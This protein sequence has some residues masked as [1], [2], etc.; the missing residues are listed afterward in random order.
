MALNFLTGLDI[1]GNVDLN[2]KELQNAVIQNLGTAPS[3]PLEGQIYYD[4][5]VDKLKLYTAG[6]WLTIPD[7]N[8]AANDFL[9]GLGFN[10]SNGV[11]TATV[12]NQSAVTVDLDGRY[13]LTSDIPVVNN[14]TLTLSTSTGLDGGATF[15]A[16]QSGNSTFNVTL[17]LSELA[18]MTQAMVGTDEFI[19]L[20]SGAERRKAAS[21]IGLSIFNNDANFITSGDLPTVGNGT[22]TVQGTGVL[23]GT[24]TF[25][26]NQ[27]T[28]STISITHDNVA[29]TNTTSTGSGTTFAFI[30][31]VSATAQGHLTGV[32]V[33][34]QTIP[35]DNT[36]SL[37]VKN[38]AGNTEFTSTDATGVRFEGGT[39]VTVGFTSSDQTVKINSTDQYQG[40]VTG[41]ATN[42][43]GTIEITASSTVPKVS[44]KTAAIVNNGTALATGDQ[45]YDFVTAQI[46]NIPSGLAFEGSWDAS[47]G[48]APSASPS[49]GQFWIVSVNGSTNLSGITDWKVGDWAIYVEQGAGTDAWQKIDNTSVLSGNGTSGRVTF[50]N[51][52][53]TLTSDA[54]MTYNAS[55]NALTITG[56]MT[57]SGGNSTNWNSAYTATN[58]FT[59]VGANLTKLANPSAI[60]F[61]KI[62]ANNTVTARTASQFRADI[63]AGTS[64]TTGTVRSIATSAPITGGTITDTGT[65]GIS[66]ATSSAVGAARVAAGTGISVAVSNGVFTVTNTERNSQN[67]LAVNVPLNGVIT[68]NFNTKDVIVQLFDATTNQTVYADITRAANTIT[69]SY[70]SPPTN[71]IRA[72]IQKI[73]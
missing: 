69:V 62:N 22:L 32:N 4:T 70:S 43:G 7:G 60:R 21:E 30:D 37:P 64:S 73:G 57:A 36:T 8:T 45:I 16:N 5:G 13:A 11:L 19:V 66:N 49:N 28:A 29:R 2:K 20:D 46:G 47:S 1:K 53:S 35:N 71:V 51:G 65:I 25:S 9:T 68:H 63:G 18:D 40:T 44:T 34:T 26:A 6:G 23:G 61:I 67:T 3:G 14:G 54:G 10:T 52:T 38:A 27:S 55:S 72:L 15:T 12:K 41:V 59:T 56:V 42:T 39:N 31:S 17:D 58:A 48:S 33:K 24:G 50:W